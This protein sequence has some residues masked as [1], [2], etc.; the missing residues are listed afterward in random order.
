MSCLADTAVLLGDA[1]A[2][3]RL[4]DALAPWAHLIVVDQAEATRGAVTGYLGML[5]TAMGCRSEAERHFEDA[6]ERNAA[7]GLRPWLARTQEAFAA[8]LDARGE[9]DDRRRAREL[10]EAAGRGFTAGFTAAPSGR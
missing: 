7:T 2:A 9:G 5:A 6:L 8:M 3:A 10:R 4:Y 1:G